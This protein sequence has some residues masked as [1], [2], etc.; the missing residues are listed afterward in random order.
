MRQVPLGRAD[1]GHGLYDA[2]FRFKIRAQRVR[3][4]PY[5]MKPIP[6]T[7]KSR[8]PAGK[9]TSFRR[10]RAGGGLG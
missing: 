4:I 9:S 6:Q 5:L 3:K 1:V 8:L 10:R 2:I 7:F